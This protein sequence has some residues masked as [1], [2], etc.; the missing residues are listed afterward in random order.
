[1]SRFVTSYASLI[2]C[3]SQEQEEKVGPF[4]MC[5]EKRAREIE[6]EKSNVQKTM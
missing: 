5:K 1:M 4:C 3:F 6:S 2:F